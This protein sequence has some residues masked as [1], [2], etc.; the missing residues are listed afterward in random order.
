MPGA[1]GWPE[2]DDHEKVADR[3][4]EASGG[5]ISKETAQLLANTYGM[6]GVD[7]AR[8]AAED[9]ALA[10]PLVEGRPEI[11]AQVDWAVKAELAH[12]CVDVL[13][14]RTQL[15]FRDHNQ[16]LSAL[17]V[18]AGRMAELLGWNDELRG[19]RE[20]AYRAE[21]A[22]SRRWREGLSKN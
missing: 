12:G 15:Y 22:R 2:D 8:L 5:A 17:P 1:V 10:A 7:V 3:V 6:R 18:V 16:G 13:K 9:P 4:F 19:L 14:R 20:E 21:V 11:L